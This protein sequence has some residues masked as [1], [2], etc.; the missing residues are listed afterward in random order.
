MFHPRPILGLLVLALW[1]SPTLAQEAAAKPKQK[2]GRAAKAPRKGSAPVQEAAGVITKVEPVTSVKSDKEDEPEAAKSGSELPRTVR[3]TI[4]TA[5]VWRDW[6]RDQSNTPDKA[7]EQTPA[8][9][10]KAGENSIATKGEPQAK[11]V[12]VVVD[13]GP[14]TKVDTRFRPADDAVGKGES[15]PDAAANASD[16]PRVQ[17]SA[18]AKKKAARKADRPTPFKQADLKP[19]LF[20]EVTYR[21]LDSQNSDRASSV[22]VVRPINVNG[23]AG[24]PTGEGAPK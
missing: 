1:A 24:A 17:K 14:E 10:A 9:A 15:T 22:R 2:A 3:L 16:E 5:A 12:L 19:G 13:L 4:N 21:H 8:Q 7:K 18:K 6:A 23:S 20:V 11:E